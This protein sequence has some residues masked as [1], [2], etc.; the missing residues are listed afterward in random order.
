MA[1]V[2]VRIVSVITTAAVDSDFWATHDGILYVVHGTIEPFTV[3]FRPGFETHFEDN[4]KSLSRKKRE[5]LKLENGDELKEAFSYAVTQRMAPVVAKGVI[6]LPSVAP[7]TSKGAGG[8]KVVMRPT[9]GPGPLIPEVHILTSGNLANHGRPMQSL[10]WPK[11][12]EFLQFYQR[13]KATIFETV[14]YLILYTV[15]DP[16]NID[17]EDGSGI[18]I[19]NLNVAKVIAERTFGEGALNGIYEQFTTTAEGSA[20]VIIDEHEVANVFHPF[21][22]Q[23]T[24]RDI[25]YYKHKFG[26]SNLQVTDSELLLVFGFVFG[27]DCNQEIMA[28]QTRNN[29]KVLRDRKDRS[30][31]V[32]ILEVTTAKLNEGWSSSGSAKAHF[33]LAAAGENYFSDDLPAPATVVGVI[34]AQYENG[35]P[36]NDGA[37]GAGGAFTYNANLLAAHNGS[38]GLPLLKHA[39]EA[40]QLVEFKKEKPKPKVGG[41][42]VSKEFGALQKTHEELGGRAKELESKLGACQAENAALKQAAVAVGGVGATNPLAPALMAQFG[43]AVGPSNSPLEKVEAAIAVCELADDAKESM[44]LEAC[45]AAEKTLENRAPKGCDFLANSKSRS[46]NGHRKNLDADGTDEEENEEYNDLI[47]LCKGIL[48][49][50]TGEKAPAKKGKRKRRANPDMELYEAAKAAVVEMRDEY[51]DAGWGIVEI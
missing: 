2:P 24:E 48:E 11:S 14:G 10:S 1:E 46:S 17:Y 41:R 45:I 30:S 34:K 6:C 26:G 28:Q 19:E 35:D 27:A 36:E 3:Q 43:A 38:G 12:S 8:E 23:T 40:F 47:G 29:L 44:F 4:G 39:R 7:Y 50:K 16:L 22:A 18:T 15:F 9:I 5:I 31:G 20:A 37:G 49:L 25:T 33:S 32:P 42:K 13:R 21:G 51:P